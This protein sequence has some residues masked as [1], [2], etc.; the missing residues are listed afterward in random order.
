VISDA[1]QR[2]EISRSFNSPVY[3]QRR[4]RKIIKES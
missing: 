2:V 3:Q 1:T 4:K